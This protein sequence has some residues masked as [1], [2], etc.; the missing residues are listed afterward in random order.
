[1]ADNDDD[2][3]VGSGRPPLP[4]PRSTGSRG[5]KVSAAATSPPRADFRCFGPNTGENYRIRLQTAR[6]AETNNRRI[7]E[8]DVN[9]ADRLTA[10][11]FRLTAEFFRLIED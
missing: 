2:Y 6:F 1:M 10:E 8:L 7:S 3:K 9:S 11:F 5:P 4:T